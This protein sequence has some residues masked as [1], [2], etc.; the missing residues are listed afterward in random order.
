[1]KS[2]YL[3]TFLALNLNFFN[4]L[5]ADEDQSAK[6]M[7]GSKSVGRDKDQKYPPYFDET[8]A[9]FEKAQDGA[10]VKVEEYTRTFRP[11]PELL[12]EQWV[13]LN[14]LK[15]TRMIE[16]DH[17]VH[18]KG[19]IEISKDKM[20]FYFER[21]G[22]KPEQ[23]EEPIDEMVVF[24]PGLDQ[25][26]KDHFDDLQNGKIVKVRVVGLERLDTF[27][28]EFKKTES[29]RKN[30]VALKFKPTNFILSA[31]VD[32]LYFF[33]DPSSKTIKEIWGMGGVK[34]EKGKEEGIDAKTQILTAQELQAMPNHP[35]PELKEASLKLGVPKVRKCLPQP[36]EALKK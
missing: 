3:F 12:G 8:W 34:K 16:V 32:P 5:Y 27:S 29:D 31:I 6:L 28:F 11:G 23:K 1:M 9:W 26:I 4:L 10:N 2:V 22:K 19:E 21:D 13:C 15:T 25:K 17:Q 30:L 36:A 24:G 7:S 35:W 18:T 14:G 33:V 20:R